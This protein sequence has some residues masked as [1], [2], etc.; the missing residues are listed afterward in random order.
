MYVVMEQLYV[1][2]KIVMIWTVNLEVNYHV[3]NLMKMSARKPMMTSTMMMM[4]SMTTTMMIWT[5]K[6][7]MRMMLWMATMMTMIWRKKLLWR[8]KTLQNNFGKIHN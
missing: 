8:K 3:L 6:T 2:K 1:V 7:T 5:T 4:L